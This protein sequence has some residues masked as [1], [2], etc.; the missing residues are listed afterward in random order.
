MQASARKI[1]LSPL[2][3]LSEYAALTGGFTGADLQ[4]LVYNAHLDSI[5]SS[6]LSPAV[7]GTDSLPVQDEDGKD[8]VD[9]A[10][11][12]FGGGEQEEMKTLSRAERAQ[13][14]KRVSSSLDTVLCIILTLV[15][16]QLEAILESVGA[17]GRS[18]GK[19]AEE[20]RAAERSKVNSCSVFHGFHQ[21][22][23]TTD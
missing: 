22:A 9:V 18:N 13:V 6:V 20:E 4:A 5:H 2:V 21:K 7:N 16:L 23:R 12:T 11:T 1:S 17:S 15:E 3:D 19:K 10:F 8:G 14:T